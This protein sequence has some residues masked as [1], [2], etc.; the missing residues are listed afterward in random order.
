MILVDFGGNQKILT[1]TFLE[2]F[3]K[4]NSPYHNE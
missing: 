2:P 1:W 3:E 4:G